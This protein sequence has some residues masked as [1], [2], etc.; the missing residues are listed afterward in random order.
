MLKGEEEEL[1]REEGR[2]KKEEERRR[3]EEGVEAGASRATMA[4]ASRLPGRPPTR[5]E[6]P[7]SLGRSLQGPP[8]RYHLKEMAT[9]G[10]GLG[11][12]LPA[13]SGRYYR[14]ATAPLQ[15]GHVDP[16]GR[17]GQTGTSGRGT[18]RGTARPPN[19]TGYFAQF[20]CVFRYHGRY[21]R[22]RY[23]SAETS[24]NLDRSPSSERP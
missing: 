16:A 12:V 13:T 2:K 6:P 3:E 4:G 18:A 20:W 9:R 5:P 21:L 15:A 10:H 7:G 14:P 17:K 22:P 23:R 24:S 11:P 19:H 8:G 1:R